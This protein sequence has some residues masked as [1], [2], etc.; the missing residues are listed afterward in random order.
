MWAST[1]IFPG[2]VLWGQPSLPASLALLFPPP[3]RESGAGKT[4]NTKKVIQYF[5]NIG[6][7]GKQSTTDKKLGRWA[8]SGPATPTHHLRAGRQGSWDHDLHSY[9]RDW[10]QKK[11]DLGGSHRV[12]ELGLLPQ[13]ELCCPRLRPSQIC[14]WQGQ[15]CLAGDSSSTD[16]GVEGHWLVSSNC[17]H[18]KE[19]R[20]FCKRIRRDWGNAA[21]LHMPL[22]MGSYSGQSGCDP[23]PRTPSSHGVPVPQHCHFLVPRHRSHC[24]LQALG[25]RATGPRQFTLLLSGSGISGGSDHPGQPCAGGFWEC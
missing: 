12:T 20:D 18:H 8:V 14:R 7:T 2:C 16:V 6:G 5:A 15:W 25:V 1:H 13:G 3:S 11:S 21:A 9:L 23:P 19:K 24:G 10:V 22:L 17:K 4:E